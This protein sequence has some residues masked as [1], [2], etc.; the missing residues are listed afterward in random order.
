MPIN[1]GLAHNWSFL[2]NDWEMPKRISRLRVATSDGLPSFTI[3]NDAW[4]KVE[5]AY[6]TSIPVAARKRILAATAQLVLFEGPERLALPVSTALEH[7]RCWE[8]LARGLFLALSH[9]PTDA[10]AVALAG[11]ARALGGQEQLDAFN[12]SLVVL[13]DACRGAH[14]QLLAD[15]PRSR[16]GTCWDRWVCELSTIMREA[17]LP[18]GAPSDQDPEAPSAFVAFV[19][20]MTLLLPP[21]ARRHA[22]G[23]KGLAQ[24]IARARRRSLIT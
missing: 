16:Q 13:G 14:A 21:G 9:H 17:G 8:S 20:E 23:V 3:S 24:A 1:R 18:T 12:H 2:G 7:V 19:A 15:E 11:V 4:L 10:S 22:H 5:L 6:R